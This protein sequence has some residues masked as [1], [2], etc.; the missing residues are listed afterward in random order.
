MDTG[1]LAH[2]RHNLSQ[3]VAS[4]SCLQYPVLCYDPDVV[5]G[6]FLGQHRLLFIYFFLFGAISAA[7]ENSQTRGWIRAAAAGLPHS[8]SNVRS[9]P[10]LGPTLQLAAMTDP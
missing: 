9:E 5:P 7:H 4:D 3:A 1:T 10:H 2:F 6:F 8:C